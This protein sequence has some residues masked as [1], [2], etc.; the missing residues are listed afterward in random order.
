MSVFEI[1]IATLCFVA[2]AA[3]VI[4][5]YYYIVSSER[6]ACSG[7][8]F[9]R[10]KSKKEYLYYYI[11]VRDKKTDTIDLYIQH[12]PEDFDDMPRKDIEI[13]NSG[14]INRIFVCLHGK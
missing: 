7:T 4:W 6:S 2:V 1:I 10:S 9:I 12:E 3:I 13:I 5:V 11:L 8:P 14:F